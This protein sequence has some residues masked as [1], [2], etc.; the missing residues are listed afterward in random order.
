M[1]ELNDVNPKQACHILQT[2][3]VEMD[4]PSMEVISAE[5]ETFAKKNNLEINLTNNQ[6]ELKSVFSDDDSGEIAQMIFEIYNAD[7]EAKEFMEKAVEEI[8][9]T[10]TQDLGILTIPAAFS[11]MYVA[12]TSEINIK[13]GPISIKKKGFSEE[14]QVKAINF[15][16]RALKVLTWLGK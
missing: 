6:D 8:P 1:V 13:W 15:L 7:E 14:S 5:I 4:L 3:Y 11:L 2:L 12:I 16:N 10:E 9:P